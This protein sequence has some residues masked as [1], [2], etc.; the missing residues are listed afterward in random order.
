MPPLDFPPAFAAT[1]V[2]GVSRLPAGYRLLTLPSW[3]EFEN[4]GGQ[5]VDQ[6]KQQ[7]RPASSATFAGR[8]RLRIASSFQPK[9]DDQGSIPCSYNVI[10]VIISIGQLLYA[11]ITIYEARGN[12]ID[13]FGY[14]AFG[15]TVAPYIWMSFV[16]LLANFL[17]PQYDSMILVNSPTL[18]ILRKEL[19]RRGLEHKYP[20]DSTTGRISDDTERRVVEHSA[21]AL[22]APSAFHM[23]FEMIDNS[24]KKPLERALPVLRAYAACGISAV[25]IAIVGGMSWFRPGHSAV[26]Q[27]VWTM[28]WLCLG[29]IVGAGLGTVVL[30]LVESRPVLWMTILVSGEKF[31]KT[32]TAKDEAEE[33]A[34]SN[35]AGQ[36]VESSVEVDKPLNTDIRMQLFLMGLLGA[37]LFAY[38]APAIGGFIVVGKMLVQYGTCV[39]IN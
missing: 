19:A 12:Q 5:K 4:H 16:N 24:A 38:M 34:R 18:D 28:L 39:K 23:F 29:P 8:F 33:H 11:A 30:S 36:A 32:N 20:F 22:R 7:V 21:I 17:C 10:K 31:S 1:R 26:Y 6:E 14:A 25:P 2:L 9:S 3:T 27:R 13:V 35:D 15:L 37:F